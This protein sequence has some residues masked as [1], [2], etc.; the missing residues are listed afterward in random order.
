MRD[1]GFEYITPKPLHFYNIITLTF[2]TLYNN[3]TNITNYF[4]I[5]TVL[6]GFGLL[7]STDSFS[8]M[9]TILG[10]EELLSMGPNG[11]GLIC[12]DLYLIAMTV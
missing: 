7:L 6:R 10:I 3:Y 5:S 4:K 2:N 12:N 11:L 8:L 9:M 1:F